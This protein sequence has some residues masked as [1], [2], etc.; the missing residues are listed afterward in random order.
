MTALIRP[1]L[2][3]HG[4][5]WKIAPWIISHFPPHRI[6]V[7]PFGG[8]ASVLLRKHRAYAE[9]YNDL[10]DWAVNLFRLLGDEQSAE[11]LRRLLELTPFARTEF[12]CGRE[13][14]EASGDPIE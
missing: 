14:G 13:L 6:Y 2:R 5:K 4:G 7:E 8:A 11:R 9:V 3:Y 1:A 10:D 12:E